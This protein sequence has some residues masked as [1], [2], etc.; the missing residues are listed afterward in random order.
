MSSTVT[1][2]S[3]T[4][5]AARIARREARRR[6][7]RSVLVIVLITLP[8]AG[9]TAATTLFAT[10][11]R[12]S[13]E[14]WSME[15]GDADFR[16]DAW[17]Q[18][19]E[20]LATKINEITATLL[21]GSE[22]NVTIGGNARFRSETAR[23]FATIN[24]TGADARARAASER[25][26]GGHYPT[27]TDP[28]NAIALTKALADEFDVAVGDI[29]TL[30]RPALELPVVGVFHRRDCLSCENV[31]VRDAAHP[32]IASP[33][34]LSA[35]FTVRLPA[36][37]RSANV[38]L[39]TLTSDDAALF[40]QDVQVTGAIDGQQ[41][42]PIPAAVQLSPTTMRRIQSNPTF[43]SGFGF[44]GAPEDD[45][46]SGI[47][48]SIVVGSIVLAAVGIVIATAFAI[49][50]RAQLT[51][52]GQLSA[53][54]ATESVRHRVLTLQGTV[55]GLCGAALGIVL[56]AV[57]VIVNQ[58]SIEA[59]LDREISGY[60][61]SIGSLV[62]IAI[63]GTLGATIAA[64]V[65]AR[66]A[67]KI[68]T[69]AA[70]SGR[71]PQTAVPPALAWRG[72]GSFVAGVFVLSAIA[73]VESPGNVGPLS[74]LTLLAIAAGFAI[75]FGATATTPAMIA[76]LEP[77]AMR[78]KGATRTALRSLTRNR[79]RSGAIVAA[80]A[81]VGALAIG[82]STA[83]RTTTTFDS[84]TSYA[85]TTPGVVV[86]SRYDANH[87]GAA[88]GGAPPTAD[89]VAMVKAALPQTTA[90]PSS[91]VD[92]SFG[93]GVAP[94]STNMD[95]NP[96]VI[97][98][99]QIAASLRLDSSIIDDLRQDGIAV[100]VDGL[101]EDNAKRFVTFESGEAMPITVRF[102]RFNLSYG[103]QVFVTD[104]FATANRLTSR[105]GP[106]LLIDPDGS[107]DDDDTFD[108]GFVEESLHVP[109]ADGST[110]WVSYT[111]GS[112]E[113]DVITRDPIEEILTGV[114][115]VLALIVLAIGLALAGADAKDE[116]T[117]LTIIGARPSMLA[118]ATADRAWILA[119]LG[120]A[121]AI[122]VGFIPVAAVVRVASD[123]TS[124]AVG[125]PTRVALVLVVATPV[126][127]WLLTRIVSGVNARVRHTTMTNASFE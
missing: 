50:A 69:L 35:T 45:D 41:S 118:R 88:L 68:P 16:I 114:S 120:F 51:M 101:D 32:L 111:Y 72:I 26:I 70:L 17:A 65:P 79:G 33:N 24:T 4:R 55:A 98:D 29:L 52:L 19:P 40:N 106:T 99:E 71:R 25:L 84:L 12:S 22:S 105:P 115:I 109:D 104:A 89:E 53:N 108:L 95:L 1:G 28:A 13:D 91:W 44:T 100:A 86:L 63:V 102:S 85:Q 73:N 60:T 103:T 124:R 82:G 81:A 5:L 107:L 6:P 87:S 47:G 11:A 117:T 48:W 80:V 127:V 21:P 54:G 94:S 43:G 75:L 27:D 83:A 96:A 15:N 2:W 58:G 116:R 112:G 125:F 66:T 56:G 10:S 122:P 42:D 92:Q 67:A 126:V 39:D 9:M 34:G 64:L 61:W 57:G 7:W 31:V 36:A 8:V 74:P 93:L 121:L 97:V 76:L 77:L 78:T 59:V 37:L 23:G 49:G 18:T 113:P 46:T 38:P 62:A 119:V 14:V 90:V 30:T 110:L 123:D 3:A 20:S